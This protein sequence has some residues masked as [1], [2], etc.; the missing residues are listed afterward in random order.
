MENTERYSVWVNGYDFDV[1]DSETGTVLR[2]YKRYGNADN[3]CY[4]MNTGWDIK[5]L[6]NGLSR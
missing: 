6:I 5:D 4:K 2:T 3:F 1:V